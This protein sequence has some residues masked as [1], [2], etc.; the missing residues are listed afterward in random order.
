MRSCLVKLVDRHRA[1]DRGQRLS[2][3]GE[4]TRT[5]ERLWRCSEMLAAALT[6]DCPEGTSNF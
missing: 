5:I 2:K 6:S 4:V 3:S 1:R